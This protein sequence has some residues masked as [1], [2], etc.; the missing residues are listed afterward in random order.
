MSIGL[1]MKL[2]ECCKCTLTYRVKFIQYW[3]SNCDVF[4]FIYLLFVCLMQL[5]GKPEAMVQ[6][7]DQ[8]RG[9]WYWGSSSVGTGEWLVSNKKKPL[10]C[11][12]K[13]FLILCFPPSSSAVH[14]HND[15]LLAILTRCQI[16]V[17]TPGKGF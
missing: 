17:S 10:Y 8:Q 9:V 3:W 6:T 13:M 5:L 2:R 12:E 4:L 16:I 15:F 1:F 11:S 14:V 7:K